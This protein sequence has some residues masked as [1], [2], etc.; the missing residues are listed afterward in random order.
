MTY[1][2]NPGLVD[3]ARTTWRRKG[4]IAVWMAAGLALGVLLLP[5]VGPPQRYRATVRMD[6]K[7]LASSLLAQQNQGG[8]AGRGQAAGL[9]PTSQLQDVNVGA[10]VIRQLGG[11]AAELSAVS[12]LNRRA[13]AGALAGAITS[14]PVPDSTQFDLSYTDRSPRLAALVA[15]RY[16]AAL[17]KARNQQDAAASKRAL[18]AIQQQM[19][20]INQSIEDYARQADQEAASSLRG[21]PSQA[22]STQ[23]QL[24]VDR[25]RAQAEALDATRREL[26]LLGP[27]T[28]VLGPAQVERANRLVREPVYALIGLLIGLMAGIGA[29][30]LVD[31]ARPRVVT[32]E[33]LERATGLVPIG[34]V[35]AAGLRGRTHCPV[36]ERPFSPAAEGYRTA[37]TALERQGLGGRVKVLAVVSADHREG[38]S[39]LVA[40][41]AY[42]FAGEDHFVV[43]VS[44][45]LRRP[46]IE[47]I[48][49]VKR[50]AGLAELLQGEETKPLSMLDW[51]AEK[52]LVL[53]AGFATRNPAEL[54]ATARL[55]Q[56]IDTLRGFDWLILID[57]PP[58]RSLAD[59]LRLA[60]V[61]DAVLLVARSGK[62]SVRSLEA[63]AAGFK[64]S[65]HQ[66]LGAVLVGAGRKR[67]LR[68]GEPR[69]SS[70]YYGRYRQSV[71]AAETPEAGDGELQPLPQQQESEVLRASPK[72]DGA[73]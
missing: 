50:T 44:G 51:V 41:L 70:A 12:G 48:F 65:Q 61:A 15:Q 60:S 14:T 21:S 3:Y 26:A 67:L 58:A 19:Q 34:S 22:T 33:D 39:T 72:K 63:V 68:R 35:P 59:A 32:I 40:N 62:T 4:I 71:T 54:L 17:T 23:L 8:A 46:S 30:L 57:T 52:L 31:A 10:T 73:S 20:Q 29:A 9:Q 56:V 36:V 28:T 24:A 11:R 49:R 38:K 18:E 25:W 43:V 53:P 47:R 6:V 37:A 2:D 55:R 13:W 7:P 27:R 42:A 64:R 1:R 5:K 66:L 69:R 45:D 16:T